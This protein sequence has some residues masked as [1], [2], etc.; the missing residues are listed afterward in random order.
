MN[1]IIQ[2]SKRIDFMGAP[3]DL[4]S[5]DET[6]ELVDHA[7][8]FRRQL[9]HVV[10]NVAKFVHMRSDEALRRD[11]IESDIIGVDGMGIVF[12][13]QMLGYGSIHRVAG[14]DLMVEVLRLC[15][16]RGYKP[17]ILGAKRQVLAD[18]IEKLRKT[19]PALE[20]AGFRNGYFQPEDEQ[21]IVADILNSGADCLFVAMS[22][23]AKE[24]FT[25][26]YQRELGVSFI[27]GV[28]GSIDVIAGLVKRAPLWMQSWG[29][30]WAYRVWQEPARMW[31]RY[32]VTNTK[33]AGII[34]AELTSRSIASMGGHPKGIQ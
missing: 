21:L 5:M 22:S 11:V 28:G 24:R 20:F 18:A 16:S 2:K 30:E 27:M 23:P 33:F 34:L 14:I 17:Y 4:L 25:N 15:E 1:G 10:V 29:L 8:R 19:F 6:V 3:L 7:M 31:K 12:A 9:R 32:L 13:A 26:L